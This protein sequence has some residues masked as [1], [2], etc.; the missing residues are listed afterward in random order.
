MT[1]GRTC[2]HEGRSAPRAR[3]HG[4]DRSTTR[5]GHAHQ[6]LAAFR[7]L[8]ISLIHRWHGPH[9]TAAREY[10]AAHPA[11]LFRHLGLPSRRL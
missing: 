6:A 2:S 11:I 10:Y 5:T 7:N 9:V 3:L 4:E 8:A 1:E